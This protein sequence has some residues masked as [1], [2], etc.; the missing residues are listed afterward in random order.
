MVQ[1]AFP[2]RPTLSFAARGFADACVDSP[3]ADQVL[4]AVGADAA[5][6]RG[7]LPIVITDSLSNAE[8]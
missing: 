5:G 4:E 2:W 7:R 8:A 6:Q 3:E 1:S